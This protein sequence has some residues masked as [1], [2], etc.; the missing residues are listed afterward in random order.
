MDVFRAFQITYGLF[1][2]MKNN[3]QQCPHVL[4]RMNALGKLLAFIQHKRQDQLTDDV[5]ESLKKL[6]EVMLSAAEVITR[7]MESHKLNQ[8]FKSG[9]YKVEF[10]KLNKSLTDTFVTLSVALHIYQERKLE[11]Q[12]KK[13]E[14]QEVQ[15]ARQQRRTDAQEDKLAEQEDVL[16]RVE[17]KIA[18][19]SRAYYCVLQ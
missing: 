16:L 9:D 10:E 2:R 4:Q 14:E 3:D 13:L 7:F 12:E 8:A 17:S 19:E 6:E 15:L 18:C 1:D 11:E 5:K